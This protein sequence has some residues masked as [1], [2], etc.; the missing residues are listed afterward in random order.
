ML[1]WIHL[2]S[3]SPPN[4][5]SLTYV[6][7]GYAEEREKDESQQMAPDIQGLVMQHKDRSETVPVCLVKTVPDPCIDLGN[8]IIK[9]TKQPLSFFTLTRHIRFL[10]ILSV[11]HGIAG[12]ARRPPSQLW[13]NPTSPGH[14]HPYAA[15]ILSSSKNHPDPSL[16]NKRWI[17]RSMM[18]R[19]PLSAFALIDVATVTKTDGPKL[20][21]WPERKKRETEKEEI[22]LINRP[23]NLFRKLC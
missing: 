7:I 4:V 14:G 22:I 23:G 8:V 16:P 12:V 21:C 11:T 6:E 5:A 3:F 19:L 18:I 2:G 1:K 20:P 13:H 9:L 10:A 15:E 17:F